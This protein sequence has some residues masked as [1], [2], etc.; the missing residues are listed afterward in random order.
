M[1]PWSRIAPPARAA[2]RVTRLAGAAGLA[3]I[4]AL[5]AA[6]GARADLFNAQRSVLDNGLEVVVIPDHRAPAVAHMVWYKVGAA[7][8]PVGKS[9]IAHFLEHLMFKGTRSVP[10]GEFSKLVARH[11]GRENAF[12]SQDYTGYF[13]TVARRHLELMMRLEADRMRNLVLSQQAVDAEREVVLEER[14][15]RTDNSPSALLSEQVTAAQFLAHP[16]RIPVIGWEHEIRAL[17][18]DDVRKFY[19]RHYVPGNAVVVVAGDVTGDEVRRLATKYYGAIQA[20][21]PAPRLRPQEPEQIAARRVEYSDPRVRQPNWRRSYLAPSFVAGATE[22]AYALVVLADILGGGPTS[23]LYGALVVE[24]KIAASAGAFYSGNNADQARFFLY[25]APPPNGD[26]AAVEEGVDGV[27]DRLIAAGVAEGE[28]AR[29]KASLVASAIY[30]RDG[31]T[32]AARIFG[33]TLAIGRT[34]EDVE[35]WPARIE[36]VTAEDIMAAARHVFRKRRSV[37]GILLSQPEGKAVR[38]RR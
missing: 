38:G 30:A 20:P 17:T 26:I 32:R 10:A 36:A 8:E 14:R 3:L 23:Q 27:I 16:Y 31:L 1:K 35:A 28:L 37:T 18:I 9:G 7:D 2:A 33:R 12:T 11:G 4:I 24:R 29:S 13:Q 25:A 21:A 5:A 22:H 19:D 15:Q 34:I 6:S